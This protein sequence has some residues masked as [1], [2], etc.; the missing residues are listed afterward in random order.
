MKRGGVVYCEQ[1]TA[2]LI[3]TNEFTTEHVYCNGTVGCVCG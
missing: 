1:M 3:L 2:L